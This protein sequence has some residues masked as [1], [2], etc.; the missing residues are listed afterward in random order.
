MLEMVHKNCQLIKNEGFYV[1]KI[2]KLSFS[3]F[4]KMN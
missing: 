3:W 1:I 2:L 4:E